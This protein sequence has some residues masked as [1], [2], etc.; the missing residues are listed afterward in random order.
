MKRAFLLAVVLAM[1]AVRP[2]GAAVSRDDFLAVPCSDP[3]HHAASG[4][5]HG[6]VA[7]SWQYHEAR[8]RAGQYSG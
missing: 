2:L 6:Y 4:F 7:G 1:L 5:C 3:M 8:A